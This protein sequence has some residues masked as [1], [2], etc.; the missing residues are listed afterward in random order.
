MNR[1][2]TLHILILSTS[3]SLLSACGGG[4]GGG[5][6]GGSTPSRS[7]NELV[8]EYAQLQQQAY[9]GAT[10]A[11]TITEDNVVTLA[12]LYLGDE[13]PIESRPVAHDKQLRSA[14]ADTLHKLKQAQPRSRTVSTRERVDE[15]VACKN[16]DGYFT[17]QGDF[18]GTETT[19]SAQVNFTYYNCVMDDDSVANGSAIWVAS[20]EAQ[21]DVYFYNAFR[22][23]IGSYTTAITGSISY[24]RDGHILTNLT[25][26]DEPSGMTFQTV[27]L[28]ESYGEFGKYGQTEIVSG[29]LYHPTLG[30]VDVAG[31]H[32]RQEF[33]T[34]SEGHL[35][36][37]GASNLSASLTFLDRVARV[38]IKAGEAGY[39]SMATLFES[40]P[41]SAVNFQSIDTLGQAPAFDNFVYDGFKEVYTHE[42][43]IVVLLNG[44]TDPDGDTVDIRY[45]W[46]VNGRIIESE[47][48]RRFPAG[49]AT[50]DDVV[51]ATAVI[52]GGSS[53]IDSESIY[54]RIG[55][56]Q[57]SVA[58]SDA[59]ADASV[60]ETITFTTEY[61]DPDGDPVASGNTHMVY[62][63]TGAS[64]SSDGTVSWTPGNL[65]FGNEQV[66][67]FGFQN[68]DRT[69]PVKDIAITVRDPSGAAPLVRSIASATN[70]NMPTSLEVAQLDDDPALELLTVENGVLYTA[71]RKG[72]NLEQEWVYPYRLSNNAT[73]FAAAARDID[74]NGSLDIIAA[75]ERG[76]YRFR[77]MQAAP[78]LIYLV[79]DVQ[80]QQFIVEDVDNDGAL[81]AIIKTQDTSFYGGLSEHHEIREI[82]LL[83]GE[84]ELRITLPDS[85]GQIAVANVDNDTAKE[86]ITGSGYVYD[87][88]TGANQWVYSGGFGL[89]FIAADVDGN[90]R[91][92]IVANSG[93]NNNLQI[94]NVVS[95]TTRSVDITNVLALTAANLNNDAAE[96]VVLRFNNW[97]EGDNLH[98][99]D[100]SDPQPV[101][102]WTRTAP[103][104]DNLGYSSQLLVADIDANQVLDLVEFNRSYHN[105]L[106][107]P[108]FPSDN[109][110]IATF[111]LE[112]SNLRTTGYVQVSPGNHRASFIN[113]NGFVM[114]SDDGSFEVSGSET[115]RTFSYVSGFTTDF[116]GDGYGDLFATSS[117]TILSAFSIEEFTPI[118]NLNDTNG[119]YGYRHGKVL[120]KDLNGDQFMEAIVKNPSGAIAV[121]DLANQNTLWTHR[122]QNSYDGDLAMGDLDG[123]GI[124]E[125]VVSD[126]S[127]T[128]IWKKSGT[129]YQQQS[130]RALTC[131][132][133]E[134][135]DVIGDSSAEIICAPLAYFYEDSTLNI[136]SA[137]LDLLR[138]YQLGD[139]VNDFTVM[140]PIEGKSSVYANIKRYE[141]GQSNYAYYQSLIVEVSADNGAILWETPSLLGDVAKNDL[142]TF[143]DEN[144]K[145]RL[146]FTTTHAL[147]ITQ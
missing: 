102:L 7:F 25:V 32:R 27:N 46:S 111:P 123:D 146:M 139:K 24:R 66:F 64:F 113:N 20:D 79:E 121:V 128:S 107:M 61:T 30:Y 119:Q 17:M 60:G 39:V 80:I 86:I 68:S 73:L 41:F 112:T 40:G 13:L 144:G 5:G 142:R 9:A 126:N 106:V 58:V 6:G 74:N 108:L 10:G 11:A 62:G 56:A 88:K 89:R 44:G 14:M 97:G 50:K 125:I 105:A 35:R 42:D 103:Y 132:R 87:G 115:T 76:I 85:Y 118:W 26:K 100:L 130:T 3:I 109:N 138:T 21:G 53:V 140:T 4:G 47:T 8:S 95:K 69:S 55:D 134:V 99:V 43:D 93:E 83:T 81:E 127:N 91:K 114:L 22:S 63:P 92:E 52:S 71:E 49:I 78:E 1:P 65:L 57:P 51:R 75:T 141:D 18:N 16:P 145:N 37:S 48:G 117:G 2:R 45:R 84:L 19:V 59:P 110:S 124:D 33:S 82:D 122:L 131:G 101:T 72:N 120:A 23:T 104:D 70:N 129:T 77:S 34:L 54:V 67:H 29:R 135:A 15:R 12:R 36:I 98:V 147:Y 136:Y 38:E 31:E 90:G 96:E 116:N 94:H 137:N 143:T 133:L 28:D